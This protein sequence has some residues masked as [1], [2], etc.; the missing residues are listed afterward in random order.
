M[1]KSISEAV[2]QRVIEPASQQ[3]FVVRLKGKG[4][5][6]YLKDAV[7]YFK[8]LNRAVYIRKHRAAGGGGIPGYFEI[9]VHPDF[10]ARAKL[11]QPITA[12]VKVCASETGIELFN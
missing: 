3:G 4:E 11:F 9:A 8:P 6:R 10:D 7:L 5:H 1:P 12:S 2:R